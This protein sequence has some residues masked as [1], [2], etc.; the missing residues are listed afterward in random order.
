[1]ADLKAAKLVVTKVWCLVV[2]M[3]ENLV[4]LWVQSMVVDSVASWVGAKVGHS[5]W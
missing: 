4:G 1:M 3:A 2:M 5:V